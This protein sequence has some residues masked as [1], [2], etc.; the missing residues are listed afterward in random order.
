MAIN[1]YESDPADSFI[2][3]IG[4]SILYSIIVTLIWAVYIFVSYVWVGLY[5][6]G[7]TEIRVQ[8]GLYMFVAMSLVGWVI[9]AVNGGIG[10]IYLPIDLITNFAKRP[11]Q[12]SAE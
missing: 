3:R 5:T 10:L 8:P 12:L 1:F 11:K 6:I 2:S 9:L 7:D 4:W